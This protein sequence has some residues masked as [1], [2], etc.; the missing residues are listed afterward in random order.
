MYKLPSRLDMTNSTRQTPS[1]MT[2]RSKRRKLHQS[3]FPKYKNIPL[4]IIEGK[5]IGSFRKN[6]Y[7]KKFIEL[8]RECLTLMEQIIQNDTIVSENL[9]NVECEKVDECEKFFVSGQHHL[10]SICFRYFE[11]ICRKLRFQKNILDYDL[12][13]VKKH[14]FFA[15]QI[16]GHLEQN[17]YIENIDMFLIPATSLIKVEQI[18]IPRIKYMNDINTE[19]IKRKT[20]YEE[21]LPKMLELTMPRQK[22]LRV[23][24][25]EIQKTNVENTIDL[26]TNEVKYSYS[27]KVCE[28]FETW[29]WDYHSP[30][31]EILKELFND[32]QSGKNIIEQFKVIRKEIMIESGLKGC[33]LVINR[34]MHLTAF[35][36]IYWNMEFKSFDY[37]T[38]L[39]NA[40]RIKNKYKGNKHWDG[41]FEEL[42]EQCNELNWMVKPTDIFF[43]V[44]EIVTK[45]PELFDDPPDADDL[46]QHI[47]WIIIH[48]ELYCWGQISD[49]LQNCTPFPKAISKMSYSATVF[50]LAIKLILMGTDKM[51][52]SD[53]KISI[54]KES[55]FVPIEI[56]K[57]NKNEDNI[58]NG[59]EELNKSMEVNE[60]VEIQIN[61][62]NETNETN[63]I[64]EKSGNNENNQQNEITMEINEESIEKKEENKQDEEEKQ[65]ENI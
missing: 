17:K 16:I 22:V 62:S 37:K 41:P 45:I 20:K 40:R 10:R 29:F 56:Q 6:R 43:K 2:P 19:I 61:E 26:I 31:F 54:S 46:L 44:D 18:E 15:N 28:M 24:L 21:E 48:S 5:T 1:P 58:D 63:E 57:E 51:E 34:L 7:L 32:P 47:A 9:H 27:D 52:G 11:I 12:N 55:M 42:I 49:I 39:I 23:I 59:K 13:V 38:F 65:N 14:L 33:E 35:P 25:K 4:Q 3:L 64:G 60:I 8:K 30:Y 50:D 36:R 53:E